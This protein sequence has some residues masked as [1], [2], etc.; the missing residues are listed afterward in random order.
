MLKNGK[1]DWEG[2]GGGGDKLYKVIKDSIVVFLAKIN[3]E[4][5][6]LEKKKILETKIEVE[7]VFFAESKQSNINQNMVFR[8]VGGHPL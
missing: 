6:F 7:I 8:L 1:K 5:S 2:G 4:Q 3:V